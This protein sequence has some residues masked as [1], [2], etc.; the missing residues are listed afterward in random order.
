[1]YVCVSTV[2]ALHSDGSIIYPC[3]T[4]KSEKNVV[5]ARVIRKYGV[6]GSYTFVWLGKD[7]QK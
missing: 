6:L 2:F 4:S 5:R 3:K 7:G 1:M